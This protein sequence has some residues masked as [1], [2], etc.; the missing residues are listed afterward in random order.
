MRAGEKMNTKIETRLLV[1][2]AQR[3]DKDAFSELINLY[4][5]D[6]YRTAI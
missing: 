4:L 6:M 5:K 2:K 3:H 1:Q